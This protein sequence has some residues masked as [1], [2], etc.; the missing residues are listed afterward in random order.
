MTLAEALR[1]A[2]LAF[3]ELF[4]D[5]REATA[6]MLRDHGATDAEVDTVLEQFGKDAAAMRLEVSSWLRALYATEGRCGII[7]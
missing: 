2:D 1:K 7:Q 4:D 6:S 5:A 3:D